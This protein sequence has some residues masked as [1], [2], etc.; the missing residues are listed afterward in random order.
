ME[1]LYAHSRYL[2]SN[3]QHM[4][5]KIN[6]QLQHKIVYQL[7]IEQQLCANDIDSQE[8][9]SFIACPDAIFINFMNV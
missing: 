5:F 2:R 4:H 1:N 7:I 3:L 8:L 6:K 9:Q